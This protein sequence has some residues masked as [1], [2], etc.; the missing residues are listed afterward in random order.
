MRVL[1][2]AEAKPAAFMRSV[3]RRQGILGDVAASPADAV[4]MAGSAHYDVISLE[5]SRPGLDG[6]AACRRLRK[7]GIATPI[8]MLV[9]RDA[10]AE[11]IA[12]LD[13]GADDCLGRPFHMVE[14]LARMRA[15]ARRAPRP[16]PPV[17]SVGDLRFDLATCEVRRAGCEVRLTPRERDLLEVLMRQPGRTLSRAQLLDGAWEG[18]DELRSNVV[19]VYVRYLRQKLDHPFGVRTIETVPGVGYRLSAA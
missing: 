9:G 11:R 19:D 16:R 12:G 4:W 18:A 2:V 1:I 7:A 15:L 3:L 6:L 5:A 8:V 17:L 14:L 10:V 13:A